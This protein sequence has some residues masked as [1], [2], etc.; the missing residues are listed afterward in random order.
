VV[1][2]ARARTT[3]QLAAWGLEEITFTTELLVSELVTNAIRHAHEPVQLRII[4]DGAL[5]CEVFDGSR[6]APQLRR[7]DRYD[8]DGRGLMLVAQLAERWGT[9]HT[10]TGKSIW[11]QQSLPR[12]GNR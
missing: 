10:S 5:T 7:A 11:A 12:P 2:D 9:R 4:L 8:E 6:S 1:A 3:L